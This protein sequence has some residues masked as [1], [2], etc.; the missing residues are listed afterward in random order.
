[1]DSLWKRKIKV[2][3]VGLNEYLELGWRRITDLEGEWLMWPWGLGTPM[4]PG[5]PEAKPCKQEVGKGH[6][7]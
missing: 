5:D 4:H 6:W 1:M 7:H 2:P 3:L